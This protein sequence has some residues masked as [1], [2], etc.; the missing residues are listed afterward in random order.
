[1]KVIPDEEEVAIDVVP[2]ATKPPT[3]ID[4]K[5]H[6]KGKKSYYQIVRA[7]EKSHMYL[8]FSHMLKSFDREDLKDLYKLVKSRYGSTRPVEDLD[9]V[10]WNDLKTMFEPHIEDVVWRNQQGY[11]V[12]EWKLYDSCGFAIWNDLHAGRKEI[13][14]YTTYNY[15][16]AEQEA[17]V[18]AALID[19]N[20]AQSKLVL[21][22]N[23]NENYSKCLRLLYKVNAAEGV[24]AASEE[25]STVELGQYGRGDKKYPIIMLEAVAS[26]DLWIWHAFFGVAG[27]NNDINVLDNSSL[28]DDLLDA[29]A[30]V[31]PYVVNDKFVNKPVVENR[32]SDEEVS[33]VVRKSDD[34]LIIKDWMS[35][36]EEENVS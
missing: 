13:S 25:V 17:S 14:P 19:V 26:Q 20:A 1:M 32:K 7:D 35:D 36:D 4:W 23:F 11:K 18:T 30:P 5:I 29:K 27:A 8:V 10:L 6:K 31:A 16:Y 24:N 15:R 33:K 9:L 2:L 3:I 12:L 28:F 34:S 22:E 21:L